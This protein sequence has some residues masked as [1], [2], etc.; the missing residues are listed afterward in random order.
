MG[1]QA[2]YY[3]WRKIAA[4]SGAEHELEFYYQPE[5]LLWPR[6]CW[7]EWSHLRDRLVG[8]PRRDAIPCACAGP[9]NFNVPGYRGQWGE[10]DEGRM[11]RF[12]E[13]QLTAQGCQDNNCRN[14]NHYELRA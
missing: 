4:S 11:R 6:P 5:V 2:M 7:C 13:S 9:V 14:P 1:I 10:G 3:R 12:A 8:H